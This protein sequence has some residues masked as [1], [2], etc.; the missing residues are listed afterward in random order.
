MVVVV[1]EVVLVVVGGGV[2]VVDDVVVVDVV[3]IPGQGFGEHVPG[4]MSMPPL[5][6]HT[7][8]DFTW[9]FAAPWTVRQHWIAAGA[10]A[11]MLGGS[12]AVSQ[13]KAIATRSA[14]VA[15]DMHDLRSR[16]ERARV[17][18]RRRP[19]SALWYRAAMPS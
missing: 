4:P 5:C 18:S 2:I 1:L 13:K 7:R 16:P 17:P 8:G 3:V 14:R 9:H 12:A 15:V 10:E 6:W 19:A 11:M